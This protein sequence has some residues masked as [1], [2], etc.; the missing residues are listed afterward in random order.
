[1]RYEFAKMYYSRVTDRLYGRV[2]RL[3]LAPL[4]QA[5]VRVA[6]HQPMLDF[7]QSFRYPLAGECVIS[8]ELAAALPISAGWGLEIGLLC[9]AFRRAEPRRIAQVDGGRHYDHRHQPLGDESGGLFR[10]SR[11]IA[12]TLLTQLRD[13]GMPFSPS[14]LDVLRASFE[15]ESR[16]ALR[17]SCHLALINALP[18]P[19]DDERAVALFARALSDAGREIF[20]D[21]ASGKANVMPAWASMRNPSPDWVGHFLEAIA[22]GIG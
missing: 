22:N 17:R 18:E 15:R 6:G 4:L 5:V 7:L 13:E 21:P 9:E 14:F 8:R 20:D 11:E 3:F 16:E 2:S 12:V 10:M 1:L 19:E